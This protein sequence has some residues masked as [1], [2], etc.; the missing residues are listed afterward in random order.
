MASL[1][2]RNLDDVTIQRLSMRAA[3][4]QV[5]MEEEVRLIL[6]EA[7]TSQIKIGDLA[8]EYFG[9]EY[10]VDLV[11]PERAPHEPLSFSE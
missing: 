2:I 9:Q 11:L 6:R 3:K 7:L 8:S 10:G 4:H 1:R 5:S